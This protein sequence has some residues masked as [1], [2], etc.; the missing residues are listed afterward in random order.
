MNGGSGSGVADLG[1]IYGKKVTRDEYAAAQNEFFL[2][3]LFRFGEWPDKAGV[4][5]DD[6]NREIF[7]RLFILKKA[8]QLGVH[9]SDKA[10]AVYAS[11]LLRS[12][13]R[14]GQSVSMDEFAKQVLPAKNLTVEDFEDFARHQLAIQQVEETVG[15]AG[16]LATPE[17]I[18]AEYK[19]E[20]QELS[21]QAVF[22]SASNYLSQVTVTPAAV[23]QFY[24]NYL[25]EY[26][27][28]DR[29]QVNYVEFNVTNFLAH[30][31]AEWAKTNFDEIVEASYRQLPANYFPDAKTPDEVKAKVRELLIHQRAMTE[32]RAQ[33]NEFA[34]A[35]F[36]IDPPK[37]ENLAA[38]AQQKKLTVKTTAP[39]DARTGPEGFSAPEDFAK[40]AFG[41]TQDDP[42]AGP[43]AG[44]DGMYVIALEKELPS[45]I[46]SF[47][48]IR[49]RVTQDFQ[50]QQAAAL[51]ERAG[52]NFVATLAKNLAAGKSFAALCVHA[53]LP[54]KLLPPFSQATR[55]LPEFGDADDLNQLKQAAFTTQIG[56]ASGFEPTADGGFVLFVQS[57]LP[58]DQSVMVADLTQFSAS[59]RRAR[60]NDAFQEWLNVE[61]SRAL[62]GTPLNKQAAAA[63]Q[64]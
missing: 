8:D 25:A 42:F 19:R 11:G 10:V 44:A 12:F 37:P 31:K 22:F 46:P 14:D 30:S 49:A 53:G 28:P 56:H 52:T 54:P 61:G 39:F 35:L 58:V 4:T 32:A 33:A 43:I 26:R 20:H 50:M 27:L 13:G 51:A 63:R 60:E 16:A 29:V 17:E 41:L 7:I 62:H 3:Y 36:A 6:L 2:F 40:A 18:A 24:T 45:E 59:L 1:S 47:N 15:L 48:Q 57:Q 55:E 5:E 21:V 23:A 38:V 9:V 64:P 34:A